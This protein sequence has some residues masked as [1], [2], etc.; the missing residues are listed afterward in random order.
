MASRPRWQ[1]VGGNAAE[2]YE[3]QLVPAMFAPWAPKLI[4]LAEVGPGQRVLDLACGTGVVTRLA[5]ERVG[6]VGRVVGL[7]VNGAMLTVARSLP[8]VGAGRSNGLKR[9]RSTSRYP[10]PRSMWCSLNRV[11]SSSRI[12]PPRCARCDVS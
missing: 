6:N 11:C 10:T 2:A 1:K 3:R 4:D 12:V 9:A 5:A 8:P 7:D